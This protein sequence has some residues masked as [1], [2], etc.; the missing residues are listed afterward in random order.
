MEY[1][2]LAPKPQ[3][4]FG[5]GFNYNGILTVKGIPR[6]EPLELKRLIFEPARATPEQLYG[7][8]QEQL[9]IVTKPWL[10]AQARHYGMV[11]GSV[12]N[13][14]RDE[15]RELLR[16][17]AV[18][19]DFDDIRRQYRAFTP[20]QFNRM[21]ADWEAQCEEYKDSCFSGR[22]QA[23]FDNLATL[24]EK[25]NFDVD[26]FMEAYY[27]YRGTVPFPM[28]FRGINF[29][30]VMDAVARV[31]GLYCQ[32]VGTDFQRMLWIGWD[33]QAVKQACKQYAVLAK[34][35]AAVRRL[36]KQQSSILMSEKKRA[37]ETKWLLRPH[38]E[39]AER[40]NRDHG[41][42]GSYVVE[43]SFRGVPTD[44][45]PDNQQWLDIRGTSLPEVYE[46]TFNFMPALEGVMIL[47]R[48][49]EDIQKYIDACEGPA[50]PQFTVASAGGA[51]WGGP[52][53]GSKRTWDQ[54]NVGEQNGGYAASDSNK[55]MRPVMSDVLEGC[56]R[57]LSRW[58][59]SIGTKLYIGTER[60]RENGENDGWVDFLG[61]GK[62]QFI[63]HCNAP[64]LG[65]MIH[66]YKVSDQTKYEA[67]QWAMLP[68][69]S[70]TYMWLYSK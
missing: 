11:L 29:D 5:Q 13:Y 51:T 41:I 63:A 17:E 53:S 15:L 14:Q 1:E 26:M 37:R 16:R 28:P 55:R 54:S 27:S 48:N 6:V 32:K 38:R 66:G 31:P 42:K 45:Y 52:Q 24:E 9:R 3:P 68:K 30:V 57:Y 12:D 40:I 21:K 65:R 20:G 46:A 56:T 7:W 60:V 47:A 62:A 19:P 8:S 70:K 36:L 50:Q 69:A 44:T 64:L 10:E 35:N 58:R 25:L 18:K 59:G 61:D 49:E 4:V 34:E 39:Y 23:D 2:P 67:L 43:V 33:K 22:R